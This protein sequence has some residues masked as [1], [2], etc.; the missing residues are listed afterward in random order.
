M[1][2][3]EGPSAST[4]K[5]QKLMLG[6]YVIDKGHWDGESTQFGELDGLDGVQSITTVPS[7]GPWF[8]ET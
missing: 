5:G 8:D 4:V 2:D 7:G 3:V 6:V 1:R